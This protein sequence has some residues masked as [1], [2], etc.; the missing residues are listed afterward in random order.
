MVSEDI[1]YPL[2]GYRHAVQHSIVK[3][4]QR[5]HG[6][7]PYSF[8]FPFLFEA[9]GENGALCNRASEIRNKSASCI[10]FLNENIFET[11]EKL[12]SE[13]VETFKN[14]R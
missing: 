5:F 8:R 1:Y 11:S 2:N 13:R 10:L 7:E 12:C 4:C 3:N 6:R 9:R 14:E